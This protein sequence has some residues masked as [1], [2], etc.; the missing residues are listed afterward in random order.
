MRAIILGAGFSKAAGHYLSKELTQQLA[1]HPVIGGDDSSVFRIQYN[2]VRNAAEWLHGSLYQIGIEDLFYILELATQEKRSLECLWTAGS[3]HPASPQNT[4]REI[5]HALDAI[6]DALL[7]VL[8]DAEQRAT[9]DHVRRFVKWLVPEDVVITF[10]YDC[11]VER[12]MLLEGMVPTVGVASAG[13]VHTVL[14]LHG[15]FDW[16]L[17]PL[18]RTGSDD[19]SDLL[20]RPPEGA[21]DRQFELR[22]FR[23]VEAARQF[24]PG[25]D[26]ELSRSDGLPNWRPALAGLGHRK[27]ISR[28]PGLA[29]IWARAER[30]MI[31]AEEIIVAGYSMPSV[32]RFALVQFAATLA[33]R[34]RLGRPPPRCAIVNL[35]AEERRFEYRSVFKSAVPMAVRCESY[36]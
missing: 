9:L 3:D 26:L 22:R 24:L 1:N 19:K 12:A 14:K 18:R 15:S 29:K 16:F 32:D 4:I 2:R 11:F 27:S 20:F 25:R 13:S 5:E 6:E 17:C 30:A 10:N 34:Q 21:A 36:W 23:S 8:S 35:D 31:D 28:V 33:E 7:D